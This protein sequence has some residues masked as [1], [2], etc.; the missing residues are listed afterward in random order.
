MRED[1][2]YPQDNLGGKFGPARLRPRLGNLPG[3]SPPP[4]IYLTSGIL[5]VRIRHL[6]ADCQVD[7]GHLANSGLFVV[8]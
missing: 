1:H 7:G 5:M 6:M 8:I 3:S 4:T 2:F